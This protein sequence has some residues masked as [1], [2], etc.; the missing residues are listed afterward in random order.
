MHYFFMSK[1]NRKKNIS[2]DQAIEL[3]ADLIW[4]SYLIDKKFK[5][6]KITSNKSHDFSKQK[7]K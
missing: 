3:L 6:K 2:E 1:K 5:N 4:N 7:Q